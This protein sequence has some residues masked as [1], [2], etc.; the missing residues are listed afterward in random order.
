[1]E[2]DSGGFKDLVVESVVVNGNDVICGDI[3][4]GV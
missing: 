2:E 3:G 4:T 1:V